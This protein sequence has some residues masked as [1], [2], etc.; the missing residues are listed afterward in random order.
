MDDCDVHTILRLPNGTFTPYSQG[1]K[2]NVLFLRKGVPTQQTWIYDARTNVEGIT[3]K[4]RPL[5]PE[6]FAGFEAAYGPRPNGD[7]KREP[8]DR[9]RSFPIDEIKARGYNLDV[10]WLRDELH[11]SGDDLAEPADLAAE[12]ITELEAAVDELQE[13]LR[14]LE[15][16]EAIETEAG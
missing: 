5:T 4:D 7:G 12:A 15:S 11:E 8:S 10:T 3:K 1:V 13:M 9:F 6:H 2:A 14:L 16:P